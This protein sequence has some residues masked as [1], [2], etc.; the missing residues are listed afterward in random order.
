MSKRPK[1]SKT[2]WQWFIVF[3]IS[4]LVYDCSSMGT[5][6]LAEQ[7][8]QENRWN[9]FSP[10]SKQIV[11]LSIPGL[12]FMEMGWAGSD[13]VLGLP[14]KEDQEA[15]LT[16]GMPHL[17][18]LGLHAA[19]GA[20]N[21]RTPA[22]GLENVYI[23]MG[24]G[25]WAEADSSV[26]SLNQGE[27]VDQ[28]WVGPYYRRL[29]GQEADGN[30]IIPTIAN[31]HRKNAA[32]WYQAS[33]GQLGEMLR[34]A[35]VRLS[36]WGNMDH[37]RSAAW[38]NGN[39]LTA[40]I[41]KRFHRYAPLSVMDKKGTVAEGDVGGNGLLVNHD[42]PYGLA[43]HYSW[44][45]EKW[46]EQSSP[47][48]TVMELGDL[49][50]LYEE[51][52]SY[53][54][55]VFGRL[56]QR[57]LSEID[58]FIG[59]LA[60][61]V[62]TVSGGAAEL[63]IMSPQVNADAL[64]QKALLAPIVRYVPLGG[65]SLLTSATTRRTG[66][67]SLV[68][69]APTL[70]QSYGLSTPKEMI[71]FPMT[72]EVTPNALE[73]L[74][75]DVGRKQRIYKLRPSLLY[76]LAIYEIVVMLLV[77]LAVLFKSLRPIR[78]KE[79]MLWRALLFS[80]L[81]LPAGL[82]AMGW[83]P[84]AS[85]AST[86]AVM[87]MITFVLCASL[88]LAWAANHPKYMMLGLFWCGLIVGLLIFYD[89]LHDAK[90][91]KGSVLGYDVM[92]G[93][94][95]Y[96]IGNEFMGVLLGSALLALTALAQAQRLTRRRKPLG[97]ALPW[98]HTDGRSGSI[99]PAQSAGQTKG[100]NAWL[101]AAGVGAVVTGY[102][103]APG[104]GTNAGGALS[105]AVGFGALAAR[106]AG[107]RSWRR[108]AP[109]LALLL[110]AALGAL[111]LLNAGAATGLAAD[112]QS[113]I[114]RAFGSL[115]QGRLDV[116]GATIMRKLNMNGHLIMVSAWSKVLITGLLVMTVLVLRPRGR[117]QQWQRRYPYLMHGCAA[118]AIGSIA[119]LLLNDSGIVAAATMII[120][121]SV[122]LLLLRLDDI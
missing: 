89:G 12:S 74:L 5:C 60:A 91:M 68:D 121:G 113:H 55:A 17:K 122:P 78:D 116:I 16:E 83:L 52:N 103:A 23:S 26:Q 25:Q 21:I 115:G 65:E 100:R 105:A 99:P 53:D 82:L 117:F 67:V 10:L 86:E 112:G 20:M 66:V 77:L 119:A 15:G 120:Y 37:A 111:W 31:I 4:L 39:N 90:A 107:W 94:R 87:L 1:N 48:L 63:W 2:L 18:A 71:G 64:K 108:L 29:M 81:L 43:T 93:A 7:E 46:K 44:L 11:L 51:R 9:H 109:A 76:G 47:A 57:I 34:A 96:G 27:R 59:Q 61:S 41:D 40:V 88:A 45:M 84:T 38:D 114:G 3:L 97:A 110:G 58:Q 28:E 95:Y 72:A 50:R 33:P 13:G 92:I 49:G 80:L 102:L 54:Q 101:P 19:W 42:Y 75:K 8:S 14:Q 56:K 118:N 6:V 32:N 22:K 85:T 104:L 24:A 73:H 62:D 98:R 106:L 70:L 79:K 36:V 69:L 35:G 30:I